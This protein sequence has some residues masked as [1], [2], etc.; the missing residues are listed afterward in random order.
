MRD[1]ARAHEAGKPRQQDAGGDG[2]CAA[3]AM[4]GCIRHHIDCRVRERSRQQHGITTGYSLWSGMAETACSSCGKALGPSD[5]LYN[6]QALVVCA[7]CTMKAQIVGDE[8]NAARNI[9]IAA[10][11]CLVAGLFG[12]AALKVAFSLGFYAAAIASVASG[13]FAGQGMINGDER[14]LSKLT[15]AQR[16]TIWICTG[17]GLAIAAYETLAFF[18]VVRFDFFLSDS[19]R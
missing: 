4:S 1:G 14:F 17:L 2:K 3:T 12:F 16:I 18:G 8:K 10:Y 9:R 11:T 5:I 15:S 13:L 7:D 6:E 19:L